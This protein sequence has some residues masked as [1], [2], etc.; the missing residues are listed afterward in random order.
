MK[1]SIA[2]DVFN[3]RKRESMFDPPKKFIWVYYNR[4]LEANVYY[5]WP[6][7]YLVSLYIKAYYWFLVHI[8]VKIKRSIIRK[9]T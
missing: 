5:R 1:W 4:T 2:I 9:R 7:N 3:S 6:L 8:Y